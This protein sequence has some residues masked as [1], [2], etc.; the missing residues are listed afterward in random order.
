[1]EIQIYFNT[2]FMQFWITKIST[3]FYAINEKNGKNY[4]YYSY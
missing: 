4:Y 1:M 2:T 3:Y